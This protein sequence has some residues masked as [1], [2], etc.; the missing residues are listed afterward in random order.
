VI[1]PARDWKATFGSTVFLSLFLLFQMRS[2]GSSARVPF[3][4]RHEASFAARGDITSRVFMSSLPYDDATADDILHPLSLASAEGFLA[5]DVPSDLA[6]PTHLGLPVSKNHGVGVVGNTLLA[7]LGVAGLAYLAASQ[8]TE[9]A[10]QIAH[11]PDTIWE[12]YSATLAAH[13]VLTKASTSGFV[14]TIGDVIAQRTEQKDAPEMQWDMARTARSTTAGFIGHGPLSHCWYNV[15]DGFFNDV[16][17]WTAWWSTIPKI[18]VDQTVWGPIWNNLYILILGALKLESPGTI[19]ADMKRSTIPL[20]VSGLKLWPAAHIV[21]YGLIPTENRLLWVDLVEIVWV[22][23]L[24]TQAASL[25]SHHEEEAEAQVATATS[26]P[27]GTA[28]SN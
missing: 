3:H 19:F 1:S 2:F 18:A 28:A 16:L 8:N 13:P 14:Y 20:I 24:A 15:C 6:D 11:L 9:L 7:G 17:H 10:H 22:T 25:A 23:I 12:Q 26:T 27:V 4:T 21:T 5:E